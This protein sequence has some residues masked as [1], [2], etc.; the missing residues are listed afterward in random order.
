MYA[1]VLCKI[2]IINNL[3]QIIKITIL[4]HKPSLTRSASSNQGFAGLTRNLPSDRVM[5]S[6][7]GDGVPLSR[8][9]GS[10]AMTLKG[11]R[12]VNPIPLFCVKNQ[13]GKSLP[14]SGSVVGGV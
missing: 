3:L 9:D 8:N 10:S 5:P 12:F 14:S 2:L 11:V 13:N 6:R 4:S 1:V 7:S